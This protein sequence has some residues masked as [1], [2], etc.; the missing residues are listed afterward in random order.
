MRVLNLFSPPVIALDVGTAVT[1][2]CSLTSPV[3]ERPSAMVESFDGG[4]VSR[5]AL[6]KG[7]V[8]DISVTAEVIA[9]IVPHV[10]SRWRRPCAI[11]CTPSDASQSEKDALVEAATVAGLRVV[12]VVDEP[13]A[14]A[15]G[16]G[17]DV[18]SE[19]AHLI[20]DIGDGVTDVAVVKEGAI[21]R[22]EAWRVG[23]SEMRQVTAE[24]LRWHREIE[25][26]APA[27]DALVRA[28]CARGSSGMFPVRDAAGEIHVVHADDLAEVLDP[29]LDAV[30][31][32]VARVFRRL[33]DPLGVEVIESGLYLS[34]GGA[35][36]HRLRERIQASTGLQ[37][38]E[39]RAPLCG[40]IEGARQMLRNAAR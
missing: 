16:S 22:S 15:V 33:P 18:S 34:G 2:A 17:I 30:A 14:A 28:F 25:I 9:A 32:F 35:N 27:A 3:V 37:I 11:V 29:T 8:A 24:W 26:D 4:S 23:C 6:R 13:L 20:V 21:V 39:S 40:V 1:R 31:E 19:Y 36:L 7:V 12:S 10:A 38:I 5:P